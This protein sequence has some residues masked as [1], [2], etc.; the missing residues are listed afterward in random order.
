MPSLIQGK[1]EMNHKEVGGHPGECW[2]CPCSLS[3]EEVKQGGGFFVVFVYCL[4][5]F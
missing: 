2:E 5:V 1:K 3:L 4:F